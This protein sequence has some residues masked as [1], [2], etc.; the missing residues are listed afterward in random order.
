[1]NSRSLYIASSKRRAVTSD[2]CARVT[3]LGGVDTAGMRYSAKLHRS[4]GCD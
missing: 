3:P 4:A 1:M 2:G